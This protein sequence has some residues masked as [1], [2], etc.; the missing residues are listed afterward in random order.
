MGDPGEHDDPEHR[1]KGQQQGRE[2]FLA[3]ESPQYADD[4][5]LTFSVP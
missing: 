4:V 5:T 1:K 2:V 3:Q